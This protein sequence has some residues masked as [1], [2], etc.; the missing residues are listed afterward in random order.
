MSSMPFSTAG[1]S[2]QRSSRADLSPAGKS[3]YVL[4][5]P[6]NV[7]VP[8]LWYIVGSLSQAGVLAVL[9]D[10]ERN[11]GVY[12]NDVRSTAG[13]PLPPEAYAASSNAVPLTS[14]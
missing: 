2:V 10:S 5:S 13:K 1:R 3:P 8:R 6:E 11:V 7:E 4:F 9:S 14:V 12:G